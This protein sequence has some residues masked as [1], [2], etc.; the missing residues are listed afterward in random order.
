MAIGMID[1]VWNGGRWV[2]DKASC[3]EIYKAISIIYKLIV[4][5]M[6]IKVTFSDDSGAEYKF[7]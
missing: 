5:F 2:K 3:K 7:G 4:N 1:V 6:H